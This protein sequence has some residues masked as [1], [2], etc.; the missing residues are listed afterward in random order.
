METNRSSIK[1]YQSDM[2]AVFLIES[3][4]KIDMIN[5]VPVCV[6]IFSSIKLANERIRSIHVEGNVYF[7][8]GG[9]L[10]R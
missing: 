1:V 6:G 3:N 9:D 7:I 8:T 2:V 5:H 4:S 10:S